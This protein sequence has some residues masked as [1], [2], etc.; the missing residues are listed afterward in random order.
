MKSRV[1]FI[2]I[3]AKA[4]FEAE[5]IEGAVNIED[6]WEEAPVYV[7]DDVE[8]YAIEDL[9]DNL[10]KTKGYVVYDQDG[11]GSTDIYDYMKDGDFDEV[12]DLMGGLDAWIEDGYPT[13]KS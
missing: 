2:D 11:S 10:D 1:T 8:Y 12:Y 4:D 13:V 6:S 9:L 7:V 5:R 3:R